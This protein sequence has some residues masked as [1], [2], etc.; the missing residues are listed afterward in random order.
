[1]I[2]GSSQSSEAP[3]MVLKQLSC[4]S[5]FSIQVCSGQELG[6]PALEPTQ[7]VHSALT[8]SWLELNDSRD[9]AVVTYFPNLL[10]KMIV[11]PNFCFLS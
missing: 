5:R 8:M 11:V 10:E 2:A 7:S 4:P 6:R 9:V 3:P 1:M